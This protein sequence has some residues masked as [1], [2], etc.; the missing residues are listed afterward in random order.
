MSKELD[1]GPIYS[2]KSFK[3]KNVDTIKTVHKKV[4]SLFP[5]MI[6]QVILKIRKKIEPK[7]QKNN[8]IKNYLQRS[9]K[10]GF[11]DWNKMDAIA[12]YNFV[13]ALTK[14][15]PGAFYF[16]NKIKIK[17]LFNCKIS[18][19]NPKLNPGQ[20]FFSN[21]QKFIKCKKYSIKII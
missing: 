18:K 4:N 20:I 16:D 1:Q 2:E 7:I 17:T 8:F 9:K 12:T 19:K 6:N 3:L 14:P 11:I 10:D 21:G 15:Y 5:L 13:R